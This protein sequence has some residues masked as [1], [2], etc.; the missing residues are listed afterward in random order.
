M[1][2][3]GFCPP[4]MLTRPTPLNC[5]SLGA[6]RVSTR[7]STCERGHGTGGN[8]QRENRR[9]GWIGLVI[10]R[11]RGQVGRQKTLRGVDR[12][13]HFFFRNIDIQAQCELQH[14]H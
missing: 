12:R 4:L 2:T 11:R 13:L 10:D 14:D 3:A 5:E 8:G 7:S 6:S 9:I 1:R